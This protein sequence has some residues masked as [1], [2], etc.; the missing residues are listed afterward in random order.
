MSDTPIDPPDESDA[1]GISLFELT[2]EQ[3]QEALM[4]T[5]LNIVF[6]S[7]EAQRPAPG[8]GIQAAHGDERSFVILHFPKDVNPEWGG[9]CYTPDGKPATPSTELEPFVSRREFLKR[10]D[11]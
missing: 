8:L 10:H 11:S 2:P 5:G 9:Q 7:Q 6:A 4:A 1:D 3:I